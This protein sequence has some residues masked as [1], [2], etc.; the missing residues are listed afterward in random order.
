MKFVYFI[1]YFI[2]LSVLLIGIEVFIS[3]KNKL[4][5]YNWKDSKASALVGIGA[6]VIQVL[7]KAATLGVF[8]VMYELFEP[9]RLKLGYSGFGGA[10]WVWL[11]PVV[12]DDFCF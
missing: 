5:L 12:C 10:W 8:F 1:P 11:A 2:P 7:T 9:L 6:V 3:V 4:G